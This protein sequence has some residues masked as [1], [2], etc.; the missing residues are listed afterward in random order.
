M[1]FLGFIGVWQILL[2]LVI[3]GI[4]IGL[5]VGLVFLI[6]YLNKKK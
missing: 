2:L 5:V 6:R 1:V 3:V 4:P